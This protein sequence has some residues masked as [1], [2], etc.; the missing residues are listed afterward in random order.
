MSDI[1]E[2]G[3]PVGVLADIFPAKVTPLPPG[4][5]ATLKLRAIITE[6]ALTVA[7]TTGRDAAGPVIE[8]VDIESAY[9]NANYLGGTVDIY[10]VGKGTGCA[11]GAGGLKSWSPFPNNPIVAART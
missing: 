4:V 9:V 3:A 2:A 10:A 8:R 6:R 11:C 5:P 1:Y 7:W